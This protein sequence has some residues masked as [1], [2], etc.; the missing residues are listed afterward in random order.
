MRVQ[1]P[2]PITYRQWKG[3]DLHEISLTVHSIEVR[4]ET[5]QL[6]AV[7]TPELAQDL[8]AFTN[9]DAEAELTALLANEIATE[10]DRDILQNVMGLSAQISFYYP[11]NDT[12]S[13]LK[14]KPF[15]FPNNTER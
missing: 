5:R 7:W 15:V 9:I 12:L 14:P 11:I 3:L 2:K 4:T 8:I 6:R 10:I 1:V 13:I